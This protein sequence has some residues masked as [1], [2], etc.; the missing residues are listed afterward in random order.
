[1]TI[2]ILPGLLKWELAFSSGWHIPGLP[3]WALISLFLK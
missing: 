3:P 2:A 1:M